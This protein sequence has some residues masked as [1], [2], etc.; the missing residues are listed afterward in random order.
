MLPQE[1]GRKLSSNLVCQTSFALNQGALFTDLQKNHAGDKN[2]TAVWMV[3]G[4]HGKRLLQH[5]IKTGRWQA[6]VKSAA[7]V[8]SPWSYRS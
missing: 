8:P 6:L 4:G 7:T 1:F 3:V 2:A 5:G